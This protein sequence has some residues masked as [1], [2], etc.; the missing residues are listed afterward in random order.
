MEMVTP[1]KKTTTPLLPS[2]LDTVGIFITHYNHAT[3]QDIINEIFRVI[4]I[5]ISR[6]CVST[7]LRQ[8]GIS[9]KRL[10]KKVSS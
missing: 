7:I 10:R 2:L 9:R 1:K 5:I 6:G 4:G 8:L 3:Q